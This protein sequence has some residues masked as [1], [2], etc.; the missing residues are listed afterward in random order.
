MND[1]TT[2]KKQVLNTNRKLRLQRLF[3]CLT[4]SYASIFV[5][6]VNTGLKTMN[7]SKIVRDG[8]KMS[9]DH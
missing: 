9:T 6:H 2:T 8:S 4:A 5:T 7:N 1:K 3:Q